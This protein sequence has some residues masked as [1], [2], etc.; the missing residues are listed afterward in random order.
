M[1]RISAPASSANLGPGFDALGLAVD[2]AFELT[3]VDPGPAVTEDRPRWH[4]ADESHPAVVAHRHSGGSG[5]L[6]WRSSIPPGRG[7][8]FS[9]AS[10]TAGTA[11]ALARAGASVD[12]ARP[13]IFTTAAE[14]DGHPD[15]A[16]PST[17]GGI[18]VAAGGQVVPVR[19]GS[20]LGLI[21]WI[22]DAETATTSSRRTL[23]DKV[24]FG[25]AVENVG[26]AALLVAALAA[27]DTTSLRAA[28]EDRLHQDQR[29]ARQP[30]SRRALNLLRTRTLGAWLSG[31]GPSVA[32]FVERSALP[33]IADLPPGRTIV[34]SIA[35]RGVHSA[36]GTG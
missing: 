35:A 23:P 14:L 21:V 5:P 15:N 29:L 7:L 1:V 28:T 27:G 3:D 16:A 2:L 36:E 9:A 31:S 26:R 25:A 20:A 24:P 10:F 4:G 30:E 13:Q 6:W 17:F 33:D 11:L 18:T 19:S 34:T 22:P 32:A 12:D 8:G